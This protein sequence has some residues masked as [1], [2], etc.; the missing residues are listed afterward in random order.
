MSYLCVDGGQTKT[1]VY[2]LE[3]DGMQLAHWEEE[4][5][6][7]PSHPE[8]LQTFRTMVQH[9]CRRLQQHLAATGTA[10]PQAF[11]FS[12]TGYL[13]NDPRIPP[14]VEEELQRVFPSAT[15][16][17]TVPDYVGNWAAVT[18]GQPGIVLI[19]GGG[20]IAY[21]Q[22]VVGHT[23]RV[24]GWGHVLG[25]EGSGYWI[26]LQ[27]IKAALQAYAGIIAPTKLQTHIFEKYRVKKDTDVLH[28]VYANEITAA[29]IAR[30]VPLV[31]AS[32]E[33][34]DAA[35]EQILSEATTH[36]VRLAEA[37]LRRLGELPIFL[38]GGVFQSPGMVERF[39]QQLTSTHGTL[40][41][42]AKNTDPLNGILYLALRTVE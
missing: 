29:Q 15:R 9:V 13:D 12:L 11:C 39:K 38:S 22:D 4:P 26:G 35:A 21:G 36:L 34:G 27:A 2:L 24:G 17:V 1:A 32:A 30:L 40:H 16:P 37:C 18:G 23:L 20:T 25:D 19:S 6:V 41:V 7:T 14:L 8:G 5:L 3:A 31:V 10:L 33:D 28:L 42:D